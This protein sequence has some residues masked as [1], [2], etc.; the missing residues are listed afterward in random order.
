MG[1]ASQVT[2]GLGDTIVAIS[3]P[4][5][6][7]PRGVVRLSGDRAIVLAERF[8]HP[9]PGFPPL[10]HLDWQSSRGG[11]SVGR[12]G[13]TS[14]VT[15]HVMKSPRTFTS[16]DLVELHLPGSPT[17]LSM[18]VEVLCR[19]GAR[20]ALPGEFTRRAYL[21]QRIDLV[22]LEAVA[23]TIHA[24]SE[25]ERKAALKLLS[26]E[27]SR[28]IESLGD[29]IA[30]ILAQV[31]LDLDFSDQDI[32]IVEPEGLKAALE[33]L[34]ETLR[35]MAE[36]SAASRERSA[37]R[38]LLLSGP[39]NAGKSSLFNALCARDRAIVSPIKGTTRDY[40]E[41]DLEIGDT[42][43]TLVDTAGDDFAGGTVDDAA[44]RLRQRELESADHVLA[45][46]S[47]VEEAPS[48]WGG[49]LLLV[50]H[51]DLVDEDRRRRWPA[52]ALWFSVVTQEGLDEVREALR[53]LLRRDE[54]GS[55]QALVHLDQR[56]RESFL[57]AAESLGRA[58]QALEASLGQEF[59]AHDLHEARHHLRILTGAD[60]REEILD[61]IMRDFCIGK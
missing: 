56:H 58:R 44:H 4:R 59:V 55:D 24:R 28:C 38:R 50:S 30:D 6:S 54:E 2:R 22:Q 41:C 33:G 49:G 1:H 48:T 34:E 7:S 57:A 25:G 9:D 39:A 45:V 5:G 60:Y 11:F 17:L 8:F 19:E 36:A 23:A 52:S 14:P 18:I 3:T 27:R 13:V 26:G 21:G 46:R 20:A 40:L 16:E 31:E 43:V 35:G 12:S 42:R 47:G 10:K 37:R 32:D 15:V 29:R 51:S 53:E 61:R